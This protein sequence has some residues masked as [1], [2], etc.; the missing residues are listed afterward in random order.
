MGASLEAFSKRYA[1][2]TKLLTVSAP[3]ETI[4]GLARHKDRTPRT[5]VAGVHF[6]TFGGFKKTADWANKIVAGD[7]DVTE[8]G[9]LNIN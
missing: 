4:V 5:R 1:S 6:F 2:L 3:D 8:D 7:V 9:K